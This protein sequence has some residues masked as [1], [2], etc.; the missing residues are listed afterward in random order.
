MSCLYITE[1]GAKLSVGEGKMIVECQDESRR[2]VPIETLESIVIF[3]SVLF[4]SGA[5]EACLSKGISTS[6]LS[7]RGRYFGRLESTAHFNADRLKNQVYISDDDAQ[8]LLFAKR[9]LRA[10]V[11]NQMVLLRRYQRSADGIKVEDDLHQ[12]QICD[13]KMERTNSIDEIMGYE[14]MAARCYFS[15]LSKLVKDDFAF[16]GR[17]KRPPKDAFNA[18]LSLGYTI[19]FYEI[20]AEIESRSLNPYIGFVHQVKERH[21]AL[22]SDLLEEWRAVLVDAT[23]MSQVQGNEISIDEFEN[24]SDTGAVII[25]KKGV[26]I[27][28]NKLE[29]KMRSTMNY[30][31][32]LEHPVGFR[33]AIWWQAKTLAG[34]VDEMDLE[35]YE[36]LRIR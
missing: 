12:M 29:N 20:Y 34:C 25:S 27:L 8:R 24:D 22:V 28:V 17:T 13:H 4:T 15:A 6:F 23:V 26:R 36:P 9:T 7:P 2:L 19:V 31:H 11:H 10:K 16:K 32:Y 14:G 1:Q 5:M 30:L 18:M 21:P 3:G 35:L 33:R